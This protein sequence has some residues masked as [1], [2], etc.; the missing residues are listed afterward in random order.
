MA[1]LAIVSSIAGLTSLTIKM[2]KIIYTYTIDLS[3]VERTV[4]DYLVALR[5]LEAVL[6]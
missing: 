4:L 3:S 5:S 2:V 1:E 6:A